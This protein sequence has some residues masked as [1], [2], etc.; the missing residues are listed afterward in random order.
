L[1]SINQHLLTYLAGYVVNEQQSP[2]SPKNVNTL[3]CLRDRLKEHCISL[4]ERIS[5][6]GQFAML[7]RNQHLIK[8]SFSLT[9]TFI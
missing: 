1:R 5:V 7:V 9:I 2:L 4:R 8:C 6:S 3:V